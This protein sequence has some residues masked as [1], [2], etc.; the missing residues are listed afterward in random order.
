MGESEVDVLARYSREPDLVPPAADPADE[1]LRLA[2]LTYGDEDGPERWA[3]ARQVLAEHPEI[4]ASGIHTA[5]AVVDPAAVRRLLAADG[6]LAGQQ[7]GPFRWEPLCYLA[8]ARHD[9]EVAED[10][11]LE[12]ARLLLAH[13]ADPNAGYLWHGLPTPFTALTGVLGNG[14]R[15]TAAQPRHPHWVVLARMLLAAGADP[16]DGQGLYN[17]MFTPDDGHLELLFEYGL[18]TGTGGPWRARLGAAAESPAQLLRRQLYW[19]VTHGLADRVRLLGRHGTDLSTP[20]DDGRTP[21]ELAAVTG[22]PGVAAELAPD[23]GLELTPAD[24]LIAAALAADRAAVDAILAAAPDA[25]EAARAQRPGLVV[26]AAATGRTGAVALLADLGFDINAMSRGDVPVEQP[27][28][29]ALHEAAGDGNVELA[30]L[31]LDLGADPDRRDARFDATPL[32]WAG[33]LGQPALV[34]L[35][36]P[37][38]TAGEP[39][40]A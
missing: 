38:T 28:Q 11:V 12:T 20:F 5:A 1:F 3:A 21:A 19:A 6:A 26:W 27:W 18:G 16:N 35:L 24:G 39:P 34:D 30:R 9:P 7:G 4:G 32:G 36:T 33:H 25:A 8:Y 37:V 31:L 2:C 40:R 17:R 15:G 29:T 22:H 13:G 14:E 10:A 23:G